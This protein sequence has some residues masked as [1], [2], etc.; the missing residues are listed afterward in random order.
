MISSEAA[1]SYADGAVGSAST[2]KKQNKRFYKSIALSRSF[3]D[4]ARYC[5]SECSSEVFALE[6][7]TGNMQCLGCRR[8]EERPLKWFQ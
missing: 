4:A 6:A 3:S 8:F 1:G 2:S 5:C 7:A